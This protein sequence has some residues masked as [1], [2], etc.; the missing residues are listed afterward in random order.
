M[1][2][3]IQPKVLYCHKRRKYSGA[4]GWSFPSEVR[5]LL[6]SLTADG[7]VLHLFG[8]KAD[9]GVRLDIDPGTQPHVIGD[10]FY[11]PFKDAAFDY[12]VM[13]PPY[14][15]L[16]LDEQAGLCAAAA[17]VAKRK[18]IWFHTMWIYPPKYLR[19]CAA[20]LVVV[21]R[22]CAVRCVQVFD[23]REPKP[24][25]RTVYQR[26]RHRLYKWSKPDRPGPLFEDMEI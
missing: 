1:Q 11:P 15:T 13:D 25:I 23:V 6:L 4:D 5:D 3:G 22:S 12:V 16:R 26:E 19:L 24:S 9:F 8:G 2:R 7:S 17:V 14:N 21:G 18:V 10:A 20:W